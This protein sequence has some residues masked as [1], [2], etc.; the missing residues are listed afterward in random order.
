ML[1]QV[2][3]LVVE[4]L[5]GDGMGVCAVLDLVGDQ[6][7]PAETAALVAQLGFHVLLNLGHG[8]DFHVELVVEIREVFQILEL[9][10]DPTHISAQISVASRHLLLVE[11]LGDLP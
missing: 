8:V 10:H 1:D 4:E 11:R 6:P 7:S 5:V 9:L 2:L 3:L